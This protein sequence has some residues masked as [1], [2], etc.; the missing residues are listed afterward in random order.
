VLK[1]SEEAPLSAML[2]AEFVH[3]ANLPAGVFN[4]VNGDGIETGRALTRHPD[5]RMISFTGSTAAGRDI[6]RNAAE[7]LKKVT[8]ELG[9][10]GATIAFA[11][12]SANDIAKTV[13]ACFE[14]TGQTCKAPTRLLV[15]RSIYET[16][17]D[18]I[19]AVADACPVGSAH[20]QGDH[21]GPVVSERQWHRVQGFIQSGIDDGARLIAGGLGKP[22]GHDVGYFVKPTIFADVRRGS[23]IEQSE[24][25]GPVLC[26]MPFDTED[27]AIEIANDTAYGLTNYVLTQDT[28]RK[29][30]VAL[31]LR[32]GM[33]ELNHSKRG[34]GAPFGGVK[35]SG[36]GRE[37]GVVGIEEFL[38]LKT[39]SGWD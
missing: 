4:L 10:K 12:A 3:A 39:I 27:Q 19:A 8:L 37:G 9:G 20:D 30:R 18:Q 35:M 24:I 32:S 33:V 15:E 38:T 7:H 21:I 17:L 16:T 29:R 1:P 25:F 6:S 5:V 13:R 11:D 36:L 34:R 14:N 28:E 23:E 31:A 26:V 2:F 22:V